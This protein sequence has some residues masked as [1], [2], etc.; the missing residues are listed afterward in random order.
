[1]AAACA[2]GGSEEAATVTGEE[3]QEVVPVKLGIQEGAGSNLPAV[4]AQ[5]Q[6]LFAEHGLEVEF[7][8]IQGGGQLL[9][10]VSSDSI[11]FFSQA[12]QTVAAA[13][14]QGVPLQF[15]CGAVQRNWTSIVASADA[16]FPSV[17]DGDEWQDVAAAL[18]G[19][20]LGVAAL[21]AAQ[22]RWAR[23]LLEGAGVDPATVTLVPVGVTGSAIA[24]FD[25]GQVDAMFL[26]PFGTEQFVTRP[27]AAVL[28]TFG[29]DGPEELRNEMLTGYIAEQ[30]WLEANPDVAQS[31]C[32]ALS[33][34]IGWFQSPE[35]EEDLRTLLAEQFGVTD[36]AVQDAVL[37]EDGSLTYFEPVI[38]CER[39]EYALDFL[40]RYGALAPEPEVTCEAMVHE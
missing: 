32:D 4:V 3:G 27:D 29:E 17:A 24:A 25:G 22:E 23:A 5:E 11:D 35:N 6:G 20:R 28:M 18:E 40:I 39:V 34:A 16:G 13:I 30:S 19:K 7:V 15:F 12:P 33:D 14:Q 21:G 1:M 2:G 26:S 36:P 10:A 38:D 37:A 8:P 9:S 31:V